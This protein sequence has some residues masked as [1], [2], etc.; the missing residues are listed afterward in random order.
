M[1]GLPVVGG[2]LRLREKDGCG[3]GGGGV[4]LAGLWEEGGVVVS[5]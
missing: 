2:G 4:R 5:G 1:N 3:C